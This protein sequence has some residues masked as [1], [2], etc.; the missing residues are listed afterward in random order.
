M[1]TPIGVSILRR[2]GAAK[3]H[4]QSRFTADTPMDNLHYGVTVR[5]TIPRGRI[6]D[7]RFA[8][9][10]PWHECTVV[11][12]ANLPGPNSIPGVT[13]DQP[14]LAASE[15]HHAD[16]PI[17]LIAHPDPLM[18]ERARQL[19]H[20]T[21]DLDTAILDP[22]HA[23]SWMKTIHIRKGD[24]ESAFRTAAHIVEGTYTTSAQ[25]QLYLE[26]QGMIARR[27]GDTITVWGS[28]QCPYYI[29][30]SLA[31]M[32]PGLT[33]RVVQLET[34][35]GFGGKEDYPTVIATHAAL[36]A[37]FANAPVQ[38]IYSRAEDIAATTKRHPSR[39][40]HRTALDAHGL[41]LAMEI[42]ILFDG[43]A[44][45]T[46][47]PVVLS[48]GAIHAA[49]PYY[50]PNVHIHARAARTNYPPRGAFR[51][52]GAP[53]TLFAMERHMD[54][55]ARHLHIDPASLRR[56][57]FIRQGQATVTGQILKSPVPLNELL[58]KAIAE[59]NYD[60]ANPHF[61]IA[62]VMHGTGF[63]GTGEHDLASAV[64]LD[65]T[66]NGG[67][68]ILVSSTE[69]GQGSRTVLCQ[70]VAAALGI[71]VDLVDF[72]PADTAQVPNSGP[73]V[74]SRTTMIVGGL[75]AEA[76]AQNKNTAQYTPVSNFDEATYT[77]DAY[78]DYSWA[79]NI[80]NVDVD[81]LTA[82]PKLLDLVAVQ[83]AGRIV[84]PVLATGQ[85]E[86]GAAQAIGFA[87]YENVIYQN[88]KVANPNLSN[89]I[90]P[91]AVDL[92]PI[93]AFFIESCD[94]PKGLG[95]LPMNAPAPAIANAIANLLNIPVNHLPITPERILACSPSL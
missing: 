47:S 21:Y 26:T 67:A 34:G 84:N 39:V 11:S 31:R 9:H 62:A 72:P 3:L 12:A 29:H 45:A 91:T 89:Y 4:G 86:G 30:N 79:V 5:S 58:D 55:I 19:V 50:C 22:E 65:R 77:G 2:E 42:D 16:E 75:L 13:D 7:I 53:Q 27:D 32:F 40:R 48:R 63:T 88:G 41:L 71:P 8:P 6:R 46:I 54:T 10:F 92:P 59:S 73:T 56:R 68:R 74:A 24:P 87:L 43:G 82:Q 25:E 1:G 85:V 38:L 66:E 81:P 90:I 14:C 61:G 60:P 83:D 36:L 15:I 95:E 69:F 28:M 17:L 76:A 51:G 20:I 37:Y 94:T 93:R 49:G 33:P 44:Y 78:A 64:R 52:F 18:A 23:T 57:N 80:A 70:I 35:G